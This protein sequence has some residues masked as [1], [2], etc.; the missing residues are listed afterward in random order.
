MGV[1]NPVASR[2]CLVF[3][4]KPAHAPAPSPKIRASAKMTFPRVG[5]N[6]TCRGQM[7]VYYSRITNSWSL[8]V[9]FNNLF[10]IGVGNWRRHWMCKY[11]EA[12]ITEHS[13][14]QRWGCWRKV[15][16]R[17]WGCGVWVVRS[18]FVTS[19]ENARDS[20]QSSTNTSNTQQHS[21]QLSSRVA[22]IIHFNS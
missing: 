13:S 11:Q 7:V 10:K 2:T 18:E 1:C 3:Y 21:Q 20:G 12:N 22:G 4:S 5:L 15:E 8:D 14:G 16:G 19:A 17:C 6:I 9:A